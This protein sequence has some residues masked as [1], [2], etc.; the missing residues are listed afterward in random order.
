MSDE[1]V[2][3]VYIVKDFH[4]QFSTFLILKEYKLHIHLGMN[5]F[6]IKFL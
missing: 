2:L 5:R 6:F 3:V 4:G 1:D